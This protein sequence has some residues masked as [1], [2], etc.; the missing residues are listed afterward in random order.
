M[1]KDCLF[2]QQ[3]IN[4]LVNSLKVKNMDLELLTTSVVETSQALGL[5]IMLKEQV[6]KYIILEI[7]ILEII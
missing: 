6:N 3:V 2:S 5:M 4:I 1:V 7:L